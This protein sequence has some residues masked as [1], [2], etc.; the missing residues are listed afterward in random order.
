MLLQGVS[1]IQQIAHLFCTTFDDYCVSKGWNLS[2]DDTNSEQIDCFIDQ[3][4]KIDEEYGRE[5]EEVVRRNRN[6][7]NRIVLERF[8]M[9]KGRKIMN[10]VVYRNTSSDFP[11]E[12]IFSPFSALF[13]SHGLLDLA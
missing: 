12:T 13:K 1:F 10:M 11:L 6:L 8:T 9:E 2:N 3:L 7:G 5:A 4:K